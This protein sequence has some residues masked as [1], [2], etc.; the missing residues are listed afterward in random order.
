MARKGFTDLIREAKEKGK[1][2]EPQKALDEAKEL[3]DRIVSLEDAPSKLRGS[4]KGAPKEHHDTAI[5]A[6]SYHHDTA[7]LSPSYQDH[8]R[9]TKGAPS[10]KIISLP[11]QQE[12]VYDWFLKRGFRGS[13]NKGLIVRETGIPYITSRKA[14]DR[15]LKLN[16]IRASYDKSLKQFDYEINTNIEVK[17]STIISGS[18]QDHITI[19]PDTSSSSYI[20]TTTKKIEPTLT[21]H[22]ELGYWR[23]KGLTSKQIEQWMKTTGSTFE[24]LIQSLCHC[25]FEMVDMNLEESKPIENVFNWFFRIIE[26][27]GHYPKPKGY[28]SF[29]EKQIEQ[30]QKIIEDKE[31]RIQE[32]KELSRKKWENEQEEKFWLVMNDKNGDLYKKCHSKLNSFEKNLKGGPV[33]EKS[34]RKVF[35]ELTMEKVQEE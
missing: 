4:T 11:K 21:T 33:F 14:I 18:Y 10:S 15:F 1:K 23:Q 2:T 3:A 34:M 28:K 20:H 27:T 22:P 6:P 32:L 7:L 31:K 24:N 8:I 29:E 35:D 30:E 25:R 9:I 16:I 13:F 12:K 5:V 26:R 17:R 19:I